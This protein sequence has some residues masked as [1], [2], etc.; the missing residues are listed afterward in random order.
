MHKEIQWLSIYHIISRCESSLKLPRHVSGWRRSG[1]RRVAPYLEVEG[2]LPVSQGPSQQCV[3]LGGLLIHHHLQIILHDCSQ[4]SQREQSRIHHHH[5]PKVAGAYI[6]PQSQ[7]LTAA[8]P[9]RSLA[10]WDTNDQNLSQRTF[11]SVLAQGYK[12]NC[13]NEND[14]FVSWV[15]TFSLA[16]VQQAFLRHIPT[17]SPPW[18]SSPKIG[19]MA[20]GCSWCD[21]M[22]CC[23]GSVSALRSPLQADFTGGRRD[24]MSPARRARGWWL[25][26]GRSSANRT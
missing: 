23:L 14:C 6:G 18:Y 26:S 16:G 22:N 9:S 8:M 17:L 12:R 2:R 20:L 1:L 25:S 13:E 19:V 11:L 24:V 5:H 21:D 10:R 7:T 15:A 3:S 4:L